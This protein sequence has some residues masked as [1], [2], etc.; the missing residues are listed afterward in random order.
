MR[1][2]TVRKTGIYNLEQQAMQ[3]AMEHFE[4]LGLS[5][6]ALWVDHEIVAFTYG[7]PINYDTFCVHIEKANTDFDGAYTV[8]NQEFGFTHSALFYLYQPGGRFR[9]SRFKKSQTL[10]FSCPPTGK[11]PGFF[12]WKNNIYMIFQKNE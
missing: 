3:F 4:T 6:G 5:G 10:L 2:T 7:A 12:F 8:I 11:M 9:N 1:D